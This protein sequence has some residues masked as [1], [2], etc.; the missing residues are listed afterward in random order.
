MKPV[1]PSPSAIPRTAGRM[2]LLD[3]GQRVLLLHE[4]RD[5][6]SPESHWIA[7]GGGLEDGETPAQAAMR[8]V[9]EETGIEITLAPDEPWMYTERVEF[10]FAGRR[11]DQTNHYFLVRVPA[12]LPVQP[13]AHTEFE[14]LVAI[15]HRWW[16][17]AELEASDAIREPI[18]M[19]E[20]IRRAVAVS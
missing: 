1:G 20:L 10:Q 13:A 5:L 16:S 6:D 18:A 15:G 2:F 7:P 14:K 8:E 3:P 19:V 9:Y 17:L 4:R 11:F 12:G